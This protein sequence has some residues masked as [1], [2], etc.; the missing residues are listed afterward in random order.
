MALP[1]ASLSRVLMALGMALALGFVLTTF[2]TSS[3]SGP[4]HSGSALPLTSPPAA[5]WTPTPETIPGIWGTGSV[6]EAGTLTCTADELDAYLRS[7]GS[8]MAG[9]GAAFLES[10]RRY[11]V[12]PR[13][14]VAIAGAETSFG[15]R[16]CTPY[17][18]FN[19]FYGGW[20]N[21]PFASWEEAIEV[22]T[23]GVGYNYL[24]AGQTT[25]YSFTFDCGTHCYCPNCP[26]WYRN[27]RTFY[28]E[29]GGNPD[30]N[31]LTF[32]AC[33]NVPPSPTSTPP[34]PSTGG[35]TV[36]EA[37]PQGDTFA[38]GQIFHP[39]VKV[40]TAGFSL[41]CSKDF[42]ENR[43]G[44]LYETHSIQG[45]RE[46]GGRL[47]E[48]AFEVPMRA[49]GSAG[50]YHSRWQIWRYPDH[51]GP[52]IDLWF[53]VSSPTPTPVPSGEWQVEFFRGTD[54][55]S[56]CATTNQ[57][58]T[59]L[60]YMWEERAPADGC[61]RDQ[62]SARF[63]RRVTFPG[64]AYRFHCHH[65][66]GCRIFL[67]GRNIADGWRDTNFEGTN[68]HV[69]VSPGEHEIRVEYYENSGM[70]KLEAWWSG[71]GFL[72]AS[73]SERD[74]WL[75][76]AEYYGNPKL[77]GEPALRRQEGGGFLEHDWGSGGIGYGMPADRFSARFRRVV[78]FAC[79]RYRFTMY[80]DDGLSVW[81]GDQT[82]L[83]RWQDQAAQF[84]R[85]V[86]I[87]E[88]PHEVR[89]HYYESGGRARVSVRWELTTPC[90][91]PTPTPGFHPDG[92]YR[93]YLPAVERW[94]TRALSEEAWLRGNGVGPGSSLFRA[95]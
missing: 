86:D 16:L 5:R 73:E 60:F 21:S 65:D 68:G 84:V 78:P 64:G 33:G 70:A 83:D 36:L 82:V 23:R 46:L 37:W 91:S 11:N 56:R 74:P 89:V 94:R 93:L 13:F 32:R 28:A 79:G 45:C 63:T 87:P 51:V 95:R 26:D 41:D 14:M 29:Q 44:N 58:S 88:G 25:I 12:D 43:D 18:A 57:R 48:F 22:T 55:R 42:L 71:P 61:P 31:D 2:P 30:T 50:E 6:G 76:W 10:G 62:F 3:S 40:Q 7:K 9:T 81:V 39:R 67:D 69:S 72:P 75:W 92:T 35:I 8:P 34:P 19:W 38:S 52:Q 85:E 27:V 49:P 1:V 4:L 47:Y 53:R 77:E 54:L 20:C 17:N 66:D 80:G 24:Q 59:Y 90:P 15:K